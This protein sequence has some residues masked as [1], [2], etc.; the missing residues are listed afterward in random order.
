M[1]ARDRERKKE[2]TATN[3]REIGRFSRIGPLW[4]WG[5]RMIVTGSQ[6]RLRRD[7]RLRFLPIHA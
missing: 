4:E 7:L 3:K 2:M 5:T 6:A 1:K